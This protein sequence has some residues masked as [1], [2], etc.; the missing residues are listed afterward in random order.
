MKS[1]AYGYLNRL[2][3]VLKLNSIKKR[4]YTDLYTKYKDYTM[5]SEKSFINNLELSNKFKTVPGDIVE[6]G[7]WKG[8]M[9]AAISELIG[10]KRALLFDSYEGLPKPKEDDGIQAK[11][12]QANVKGEF[13][14]DNCSAEEAFAIEAMTMSGASFNSFQGWFKDTLNNKLPIEK[15]SILRLDVDWY[16][17]TMECL[18]YLFP[19]LSK[20]GIVLID[21]YYTWEGCS[22]A[23]HDYLSKIKSKSRV[24]QFNNNVAYII[25]IDD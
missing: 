1:K 14:Y 23:V 18:T 20:G 4:R 7:V 2:R 8:G 17:S 13:Y 21:D 5:V 6:C 25:K 12:W 11:L 24:Y 22:K 16:D 3:T 10:N 15:I 9:I 19:L